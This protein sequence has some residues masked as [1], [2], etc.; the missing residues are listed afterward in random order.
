MHKQ[1]TEV[2]EPGSFE[3]PYH[4]CEG[5][6]KMEFRWDDENDEPILLLDGV[7]YDE[8]PYLS[9][10]FKLSE[11]KISQ[12]LTNLCLNGDILVTSVEE[13]IEWEPH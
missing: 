2:R 5:E 1:W 8:L 10:D 4:H 9:P 13:P 7:R 11:Q 3:H 12:Y 6:L